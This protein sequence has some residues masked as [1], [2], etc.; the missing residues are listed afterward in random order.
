MLKLCYNRDA[1]ILF[2]KLEEAEIPSNIVKSTIQKLGFIY[3]WHKQNMQYAI[4]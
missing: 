3:W 2:A 4:R 1:Y